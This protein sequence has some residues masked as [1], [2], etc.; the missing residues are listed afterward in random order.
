MVNNFR[1][2]ASVPNNLLFDNRISCEWIATAA[3]A[4]Y[5]N[6]SPNAL[7]IMVH[8]GQVKAHKLGSRLRFTLRDL[9][10]TLQKRS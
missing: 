2:A 7:R 5:L 8:R 10:E 9:R 3:A 4:T 1:L 6:I